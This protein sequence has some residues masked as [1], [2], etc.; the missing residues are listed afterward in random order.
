MKNINNNKI[1]IDQTEIKARAKKFIAELGIP[2]TCFCKNIGISSSAF[3]RWQR[4]DLNLSETTVNRISEYL[5]RY[6][7]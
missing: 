4:N 6:N 2:V 7:F 5:K 3:N 1:K